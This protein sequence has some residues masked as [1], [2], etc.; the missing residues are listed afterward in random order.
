MNSSKD[1]DNLQLPPMPSI[2]PNKNDGAHDRAYQ[3]LDSMGKPMEC[4]PDL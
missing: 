2:S 3:Y 4:D 1:F